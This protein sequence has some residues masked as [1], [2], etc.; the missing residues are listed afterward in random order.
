MALGREFAD[1]R[2]AQEVLNAVA[3]KSRDE[4]IAWGK[5]RFGLVWSEQRFER[6]PGDVTEALT[7]MGREMQRWE[8]TRLEQYVLL[9][10]YDQAWKD[11]LL[12]MDHL[13][14]SIMQRPLG[15]DQSHPQSQY[16]IEGRELFNKMWAR[17]AARVTDVIF[18]VRETGGNGEAESG[19]GQ[20]AGGS[21]PVA[22]TF[23][24]ADATGAGFGGASADQ[25]AAMR[26]Q[27]VEA[28][29]ETIRREAPRV[30]RNDPCPCG[31]GKKY[32]QCHGR[33]A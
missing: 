27:N 16:A 15:G 19:A 25:T 10:I 3:G 6:S 22:M 4:A 18:K 11:H 30:G 32:K 33:G 23:R 31:S 8:L 7:V 20:G 2:L 29:P 1:G 5:S 26:A 13:K 17:I 9:R 28:K 12:E 21:A 24:H 14:T